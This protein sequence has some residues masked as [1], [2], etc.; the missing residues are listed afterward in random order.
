MNDQVYCRSDSKYA[1]RP[2]AMMWEGEKLEIKDILA[3]WRTP[4]GIS[5]HV[6]A[7]NEQLF[8]LHYSESIDNWQIEQP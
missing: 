2:V 6:L 3:S 8:N 4:D 7:V 1:E 5:F